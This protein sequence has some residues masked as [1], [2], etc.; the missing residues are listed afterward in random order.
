MNNKQLFLMESLMGTSGRGSLGS[1]DDVV[2]SINPIAEA[3]R[4]GGLR[5]RIA[6]RFTVNAANKITPGDRIHVSDRLFNEM[7]RIYFIRGEAS[8]KAYTLSRKNNT[9]DSRLMVQLTIKKGAYAGSA[10]RY[11]LHYDKNYDSYYID[12]N[13]K[14]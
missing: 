2:V 6:F 3:T 11:N 12:I 13:Q 1:D 5:D 7:G 9:K 4:D 14:L 10:G 8:E